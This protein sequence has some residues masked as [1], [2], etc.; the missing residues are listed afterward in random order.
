MLRSVAKAAKSM[1]WF[2]HWLLLDVFFN[3]GF[4]L[5][6]QPQRRVAFN[7]SDLVF[8]IQFLRPRRVS[9]CASRELDFGSIPAFL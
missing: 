6:P 9:K 4:G 7:G 8:C 5:K 3:L 1:A 2:L